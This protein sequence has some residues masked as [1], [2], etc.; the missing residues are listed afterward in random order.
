VA[1][2]EVMERL[3]QEARNKLHLWE[4]GDWWMSADEE[5][6]H[7]QRIE[8]GE[9]SGRE[10]RHCVVQYVSMQPLGRA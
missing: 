7:N 4:N 10:E 6:A 1:V 3:T 8:E 9:G 5:V 2:E